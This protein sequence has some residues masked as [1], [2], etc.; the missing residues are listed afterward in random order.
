M[1]ANGVAIKALSERLGHSNVAIALST[2]THAYREQHQEIADKVGSLLYA[3]N[4][5]TT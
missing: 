5:A 2:Y 3:A 1:L 4:Q